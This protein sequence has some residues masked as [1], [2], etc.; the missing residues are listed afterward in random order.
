MASPSPSPAISKLV[1][2]F[3][4]S[5]I[6]PGDILLY[7]R[8]GLMNKLIKFKRGEKYSHVAIASY[9]NNILEAVQ[10]Q[11]LGEKPIR[12]DGLKA[13]YRHHVPV[14]FDAGYEWF[15]LEAKGQKYDWLGLLSFALASFQGR[16]NNKMFCSEFVARFFA[17]IGSPLFAVDMDAD[18]V[19]PGM[20]PYSHAVHAVWIHP[21]KR[22]K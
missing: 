5:I 15:E 18:A 1:D 12:L 6:K 19:S 11:T 22:K 16:A 8:D 17:K 21:D 7:D 2:K 4:I 10:G 13:I 14:D 3:A 20:I 9:P